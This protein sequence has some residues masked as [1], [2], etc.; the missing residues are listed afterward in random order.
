MA[1]VEELSDN[2]LENTI[3]HERPSPTRQRKV[4]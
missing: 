3:G 4:G 2:P 1:N